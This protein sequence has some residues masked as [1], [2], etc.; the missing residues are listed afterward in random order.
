MAKKNGGKKLAQSGGGPDQDE[1]KAILT[2]QQ[3]PPR[4]EATAPEA[5]SEAETSIA[6]KAPETDTPEVAPEKVD[7]EAGRVS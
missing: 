1:L 5:G 2:K 6:P 3:L 4:P 7:D